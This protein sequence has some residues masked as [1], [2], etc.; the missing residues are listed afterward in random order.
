MEIYFR[1]NLDQ[2]IYKSIYNL[3]KIKSLYSNMDTISFWKIGSEIKLLEERGY[4]T[5]QMETKLHIDL[6]LFLFSF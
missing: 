3:D 6:Y 5:K 2:V 1:N 4:S